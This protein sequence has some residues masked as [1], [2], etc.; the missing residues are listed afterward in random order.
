MKK[1][2]QMTMQTYENTQ[3][4][5]KHFSTNKKKHFLKKNFQNS[6]NLKSVSILKCISQSTKSEIWY[7]QTKKYV[8]EICSLHY[9]TI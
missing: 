4:E 7:K 2:L 9:I 1:T 8:Y 6:K 5:R 3:F